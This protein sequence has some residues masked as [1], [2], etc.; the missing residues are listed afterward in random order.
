[1]ATR[2]KGPVCHSFHCPDGHGAPA[3]DVLAGTVGPAMPHAAEVLSI[4]IPCRNTKKGFDFFHFIQYS[5][6]TTLKLFSL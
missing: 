1:M 3:I 6:I 4:Q 2:L 5:M